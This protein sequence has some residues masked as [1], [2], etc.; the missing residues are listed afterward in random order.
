MTKNDKFFVIF[1]I[2]NMI[3]Q[4]MLLLLMSKFIFDINI[5]ENIHNNFRKGDYLV[6]V[7]E[8]L[9]LRFFY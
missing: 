2:I 6:V 5:I 3:V 4:S 9:I 8:L 7:I 1:K